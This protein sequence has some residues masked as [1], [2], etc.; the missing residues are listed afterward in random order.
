M[1][2][3]GEHV[4]LCIFVNLLCLCVEIEGNMLFKTTVCVLVLHC[5]VFHHMIVQSFWFQK[6]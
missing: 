1:F 4:R 3:S 5:P 2:S 6:V